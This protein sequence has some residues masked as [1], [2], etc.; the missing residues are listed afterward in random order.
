MLGA[1]VVDQG[2]GCQCVGV[3]GDGQLELP[4][5]EAVAG[6]LRDL[7]LEAVDDLPLVLEQREVGEETHVTGERED[8]VHVTGAGVARGRLEEHGLVEAAP[9]VLGGV[10]EVLDPAG[11]AVDAVAGRVVAGGVGR[12]GGGGGGGEGIDGGVDGGDVKGDGVGGALHEDDGVGGVDEIA[13]AGA[14]ELAELLHLGLDLGSGGG[15]DGSDLGD[16]FGAE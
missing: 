13:V 5:E 14:N 15:L 9:D 12:V 7:R 8:G 11:N 1:E 4:I 16:G 2:N 10:D 6:A 3:G